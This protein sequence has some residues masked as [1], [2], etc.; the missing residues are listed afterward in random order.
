MIRGRKIDPHEFMVGLHK[1][2]IT[3]FCERAIAEHKEIKLGVSPAGAG[4]N[5]PI[6]PKKINSWVSSLGWRMKKIFCGRCGRVLAVP[7]LD[8]SLCKRCG[9]V[10]NERRNSNRIT[11]EPLLSPRKAKAK[12]VKEKSVAQA[13]GQISLAQLIVGGGQ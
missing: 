7:G 10:S 6:L 12:S 4:S 3:P 9:W 11:A 1:K 8:H 13:H 5:T 2:A